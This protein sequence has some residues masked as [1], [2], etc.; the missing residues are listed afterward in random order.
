MEGWCFGRIDALNLVDLEMRL[1]RMELD[2]VNGEPISNRSLFG[3]SAA[4]RAGR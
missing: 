2:L 4:C 1:R 3:A